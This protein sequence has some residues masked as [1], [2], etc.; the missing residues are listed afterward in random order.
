[1]NLVMF[2]I[3]GTLTATTD[4]D[5]KCFLQA[6]EHVFN[7]RDIDTDLTTYK[8]VTDEGIASEIIERHTGH[9][10]TEEQLLRLR[11]S[12]VELLKET[13]SRAPSLFRPITGARKIMDLL[14]ADARSCI[15]LATGGW[16]ESATFKMQLAGLNTLNIP[17]ATSNHAISR[18]AIMRLSEKKARHYYNIGTFDSIVYIGDGI[19]DLKSSRALGYDF[20]GIGTNN[21]AEI[22]RA[23]GAAH[24]IPDFTDTQ[25]I[26][27]ILE[28]FCPPYQQR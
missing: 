15:S 10:A 14:N 1:M 11:A 5:E 18:E 13:A 4:I 21:G 19:W 20:I 9:A 2:D 28:A 25:G 6:M 8:H 27:N 7:I 22:L 26:F 3:D 16:T 24:I 12:F 23:Q 17:M